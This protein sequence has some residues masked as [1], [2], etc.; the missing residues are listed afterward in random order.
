MRAARRAAATGLVLAESQNIAR[1]LSNQPGNELPPAK[2]AAA[3][4]RVA[5]ATGL[6]CRIMDVNELKRRKMGGIL[7]VG[8]GSSSQARAWTR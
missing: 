4:R 8:A 5:Q 1:D 3:A 7:A 2:L 6:R